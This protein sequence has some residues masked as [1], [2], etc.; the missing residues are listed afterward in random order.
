MRNIKKL[1]YILSLILICSFIMPFRINASTKEGKVILIDPGHGG[2]DGGASSK[3]GTVEKDINLAISLKL[4][5]DLESE[6]Y[7][8]KLTREIDEGLYEKGQ[9]IKEKKREDLNNRRSM[10]KD[11]SCDVFISIHQNMFPQAKCFG[12]QT[13]YATN[14]KSLK[15]A[16]SIQN[17]LK[18]T[19]PD[20]NKRVSKPAGDAY[21]ILRDEYDCAAI[22][23]ECGFLSNPEEEQ[24]LKSEE[25]QNLMVNGIKLGLERYFEE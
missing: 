25:H 7:T 24:R 23:L 14:E 12:A 21:L 4:K 18:E 2:F 9:T 16:E 6:G 11:I 22:L 20:G 5:S 17:A 1:G 3:N 15:L 10:K 19:I 8:V 13:W